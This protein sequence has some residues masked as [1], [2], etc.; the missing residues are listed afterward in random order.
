VDVASKSTAANRKVST[1]AELAV[2][3]L[4]SLNKINECLYL[5]TCLREGSFEV[6]GYFC[7]PWRNMKYA[8]HSHDWVSQG[9]ERIHVCPDL[10]TGFLNSKA[11]DEFILVATEDMFAIILFSKP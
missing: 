6:V 4:K 5:G 2:G 11:V 9:K 10:R 1:Q 8:R 7:V 3:T